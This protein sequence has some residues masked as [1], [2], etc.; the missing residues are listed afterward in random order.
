MEELIKVTEERIGD[1]VINSVNARDLWEYLESKQ[2][3]TDWIRYRI[4][5]TRYVE[6]VDYCSFH[7]NVK[8]TDGRG[9]QRKE[10]IISL[11]VAKNF[12]MMEHNEKGDE[13]RRYFIEV[14]KRMLQLAKNPETAI[15][16]RNIQTMHLLKEEADIQ[17]EIWNLDEQAKSMYLQDR[18]N[19]Y[20]LPIPSNVPLLENNVE[21]LYER[22]QIYEMFGAVGK[23]SKPVKDTIMNILNEIDLTD[24]NREYSKL[25]Y[26]SRNGHSDT[27]FKY[28]KAAIELVHEK[29]GFSYNIV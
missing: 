14:E 29:T 15:I 3:F 12:A 16:K 20:S 24:D 23:G 17:C 19:T 22:R 8:R 2:K 18:Y 13:V 11:E 6:G 10:Y 4:K 7:K 1:D 25:V 5:K 27:M 28:K 21:K 9:T 26:Y